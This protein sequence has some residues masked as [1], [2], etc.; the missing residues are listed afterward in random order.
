MCTVKENAFLVFIVVFRD[1][2]LMLDKSKFKLLQSRSVT[3]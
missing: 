1:T 2:L 3:C